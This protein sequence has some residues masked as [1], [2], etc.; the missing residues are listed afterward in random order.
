MP[1]KND[2]KILKYFKTLSKKELIKLLMEY[3][4]ENFKKEI[5][6]RDVS[7]DEL[8]RGLNKISSA[9]SSILEDEELLYAPR[10]FQK[11]ISRYMEDLKAF[12]NQDPKKVMKIA[13]NLALEIEVEQENGYLWTD[14]YY[15]E[16]YFD[17][18]IFSDEIMTLIHKI[19]DKD[20]Q[21]KLF[22]DFGEVANSSGYLAFS[23]DT[24][25]LEDKT[26]LLAYFNEESTLSFYNTIKEL[27][28][29]EEKEKFLLSAGSYKSLISF[30]IENDKANLAIEKLEALLKEKFELEYVEKL[31]TLTSISKERL[32]E[33]V[34][35]TIETS[36][37]EAFDFIIDGFKKLENI[38]DLE[39]LWKD[40]S[41]SEY[42][43]YLEKEQR[44][45][46]MYALLNSLPE[47]R[48]KFLK[49]YKLAY[50]EE[51]IAFFNTQITENLK[52]TGN[53]YYHKISEALWQLKALI[54]EVELKSRVEALKFEYKRRRNFVGILVKRFG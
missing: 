49:K 11:E 6:L 30:Y 44:I 37:Y 4:P 12:V 36:P 46:E 52:T 35:Q 17:F 45:D 13:F 1:V 7:K 22:M 2:T 31:L 29:Y 26:P 21:L 25:E 10:K 38:E 54:D 48:E 27:L 18:D 16:E 43:Q 34:S 19:S 23:Y 33:F 20:L 3:S 50:K 14:H 41:L 39:R 28:S 40:K 42:Y 15:E 32:R 5:L 51:A 8:K 24:L 9:L 53:S 47:N